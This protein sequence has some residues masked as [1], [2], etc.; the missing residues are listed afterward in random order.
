MEASI[1][2]PDTM[3]MWHLVKLGSAPLTE[4]SRQTISAD[5]T[6]IVPTV[7]QRYHTLNGRP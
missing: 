5:E 2:Y 7:R 1:N 4:R 6:L 3:I